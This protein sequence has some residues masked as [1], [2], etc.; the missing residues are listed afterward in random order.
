MQMNTLNKY[1]II[2]LGF[3]IPVSTGATNVLLGLILLIWISDSIKNGFKNTITPLKSNPVALMGLM[4]FLVYIAGMAYTN[5][6]KAEALESMN[7]AAKFLFIPIAMIYLKDKKGPLF[8]MAGF[9]SAMLVV[10]FFSY[11]IRL[12]L[13]PAFIPVK[14][15]R[16][17]CTVF[18]HH[19]TQ[20]I[21]MA[22]IAFIFAVWARFASGFGQKLL[23]AALSFTA[24]FN[25][26]FLVL[27]RT[28]HLVLAVLLVYFFITWSGRKS[29]LT[30][31]LVVFSIGIL[32]WMV[33]SNA[34]FSRIKTAVTEVRK[35]E[36]G[37]PASKGSSS[38]LRLEYFFNT[39]EL[40]RKNPVIGTGTGSFKHNYHALVNGTDMD[41]TDNPHNE[42]LFMT[43]QFGLVGLIILLA[44]FTIQWRYAAFLKDRQTTILCR[45]F[46][47]T[48][49]I[50]CMVSSPL[51]DSA[52]GWFFAF[53]SALFFS[54]IE[55]KH[56]KGSLFA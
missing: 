29:I 19:I 42:Y 17:N 46:V 34:L 49:I 38:G 51:Q 14:G 50:S 36:Y 33:P 18:F 52:E 53:M 41:K 56:S 31:L 23:W 48:I 7:D 11:L 45:G 1:L 43:V 6:E 3:S 5:I 40:I 47:L 12:D 44:F 22:Y 55:S 9:I 27:G 28:G 54:N 37:K 35:W 16:L 8:L 39:V 21:F 26:T 30:A 25:V 24:L 20:N 15:S 10:L 13:L 4:I 2:L 32:A